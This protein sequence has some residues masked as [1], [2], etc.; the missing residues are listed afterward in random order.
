MGDSVF[1]KLIS[2]FLQENSQ[3][4]NQSFCFRKHKTLQNLRSDILGEATRNLTNIFFVCY[5]NIDLTDL[6]RVITSR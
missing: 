4:Y 3:G 1:F 6:Q 2:L 5:L